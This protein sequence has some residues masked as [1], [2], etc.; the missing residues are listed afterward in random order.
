M[1]EKE[2]FALAERVQK[3]VQEKHPHFRLIKRRNEI[4]KKIKSEK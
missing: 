1:N 2:R 3:R 4:E